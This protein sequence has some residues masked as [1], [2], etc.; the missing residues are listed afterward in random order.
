MKRIVDIHQG[1]LIIQ[2]RDGGG[3]EAI[4]SLPLVVVGEEEISSHSPIQKIKQS[5]SDRF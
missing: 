5:I 4:I 3:L 2:N 1:E